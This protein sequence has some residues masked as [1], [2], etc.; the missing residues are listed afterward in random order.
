MPA[1]AYATQIKML[2]FGMDNS[3]PSERRGRRRTLN[4]GL[5]SRLQPILA[6]NQGKYQ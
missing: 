3:H 5:I 2:E 4:K 1:F 6:D